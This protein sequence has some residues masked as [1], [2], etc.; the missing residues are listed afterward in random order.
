[1]ETNKQLQGKTNSFSSEIGNTKAVATKLNDQ[2]LF[3]SCKESRIEHARSFYGCFYLGPFLPGQSLTVANALRRTLLSDLK[4]LAITSVEIEGA[5]HEYS[6]LPGIRESVL[7]ILLNLKEIVFKT[8]K[9]LTKPQLAYLQVR[10]PGVVRSGDLKLPIGTQ[11][12]DPNQY[13]ATLAEDGILNMRVKIQQGKNYRIQH[14]TGGVNWKEIQLRQLLLRKLNAL[15]K[16]KSSSKEILSLKSKPLTID[17]VFM[18]VTKVNYV[19]EFETKGL[20]SDHTT[21]DNQNA[22]QVIILE[23]WTNGSIL[24]R[25]ALS[26]ALKKLLRIFSKLEKIQ[27]RNSLVFKTLI[28]SNKNYEKVLQKLDSMNFDSKTGFPVSKKSLLLKQ[29]AFENQMSLL[30]SHQSSENSSSLNLTENSVSP[31]IHS[32]VSGSKF[33]HIAFLTTEAKNYWTIQKLKLTDI[34][35]LNISLRPYTCLKRENINSL[36][37]L[38]KYSKEQLLDFK[39]FGRKSL[40]EIEKSLLEIGIRFI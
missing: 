10:G 24:P 37:D 17:A 32:H 13:I 12:V 39:N 27:I 28:Q 36:F 9:E 4:G 30:T 33:E 23:I 1:M 14:S 18:P 25:M 2:M 19:I 20:I 7:D 26:E 11:C 22:A 8:N 35:N 16:T 34:G 15:Q 29:K 21:N 5:L 38:I 3:I 31:T 40:E 6:T